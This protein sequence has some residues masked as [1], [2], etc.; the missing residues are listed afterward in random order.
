MSDVPKP[1]AAAKEAADCIIEEIT[2]RLID[3]GA[4]HEAVMAGSSKA[5]ADAI[6]MIID[7][8]TTP[9]SVEEWPRVSR[10]VVRDLDDEY[11][12]GVWERAALLELV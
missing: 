3:A 1:S 2:C 10:G 5:L 12:K 11:L 8:Y 7:S 9:R 4:E 6:T